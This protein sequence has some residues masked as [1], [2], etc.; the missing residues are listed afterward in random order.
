VSTDF[1]PYHPLRLRLWL[2]AGLLASLALTLWAL[3]AFVDTQSPRD[4]LRAGLSMGLVAAMGWALFRLRPRAGWG[5]QV[6]PL[7]VLVSKAQGGLIEVPWSAVKE[8]RRLGEKRDTLGLW[9]DEERRVLV[10][11]HLFARREH[12]EAFA[13]AIDERRPAQGKDEQSLN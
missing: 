4:I 11:A 2:A 12:F 10:P 6:T 3:W 7:S 1:F 8:V 13:S 5:V 9:L